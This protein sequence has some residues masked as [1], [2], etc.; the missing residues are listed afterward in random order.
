MNHFTKFLNPCLKDFCQQ[1]IYG[2]SDHRKKLLEIKKKHPGNFEMQ[3]EYIKLIHCYDNDP[4]AYYHTNE[5]CNKL[6]YPS[7]APQPANNA[8]QRPP[9]PPANNAPHRPTPPP[10]SEKRKS[11]C[12]N[13]FRKNKSGDCVEKGKKQSKN[14]EQKTRQA[15]NKPKRCP[16]GTRKNKH[17]ECVPKK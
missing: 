8:P 7:N 9:P 6:G 3:D 5:Q 12:R 16:N 17:G 11:R 4:D 10:K 13:G 14:K 15:S 1:K 2:K